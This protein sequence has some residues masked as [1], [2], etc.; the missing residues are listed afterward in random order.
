[1]IAICAVAL[2]LAAC[3]GKSDSVKGAA[4]ESLGGN[5]S[6]PSVP[7][8]TAMTSTGATVHH[9]ICPNN[10]EG[11]GGGAPG[12]CPVCGTE[13]AHN[14]AWHNQAQNSAPAEMP[15]TTPDGREIQTMTFPGSSNA[16]PIPTPT[17]TPEPAQN[18]AGVWHYIC[19]KGCAGG[20]GAAG[21]CAKCGGALTH[22]AAYHQ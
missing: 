9:Y 7:A 11:S 6:A 17:S 3:G 16:A 18:A 5:Q 10:C 12:N 8:G 1:M 14:Q 22:N 21:S 13:Y 4:R 15:A 2:S 20:A 19:E